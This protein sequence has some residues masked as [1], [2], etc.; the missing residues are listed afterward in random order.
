[1]LLGVCALAGLGV[2]CQ[3]SPLTAPQGTTITFL[4]P[5]TMIASGS[6]DVVVSVVQGA[7]ST[8]TG[9]GSGGNATTPTG[10]Q[11]VHDNTSVFFTTSLGTIAP[12]EAKTTNGFATVTLVGDGHTGTAKVVATSGSISGNTSI[13]VTASTVSTVSISLPGGTGVVSTPANFT[14]GVG[15]STGVSDVTVDFGDGSS[16]SVGAIATNGTA[17]ATH[18]YAA[19]GTYQVVARASGNDGG[20]ATNTT[21]V[22]ISPLTLTPSGPSTIAVGA[23]GSYAVTPTTGAFI[24]HYEWDFGDGTTISTPTNTQTHVYTTTGTKTVTVNVVPAAGPARVV[25]IQVQVT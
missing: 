22:A 1:M 19:S 9:I 17:T 18:L 4:S 16:Q 14:V 11:P 12:V 25:T 5:T 3:S 6:M 10:G 15:A 24:D 23:S 20:T 2:S 21:T 8:G 13:T 7:T